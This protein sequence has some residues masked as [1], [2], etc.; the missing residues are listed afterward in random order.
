ML[1]KLSISSIL[2]F[3][4]CF[5]IFLAIASKHTQRI[6]LEQLT[7]TP[8]LFYSI[9][10][11]TPEKKSPT[12]PPVKKPK[13]SKK[14]PPPKKSLPKQQQPSRKTD[15]TPQPQ[16][17]AETI[18]DIT[19]INQQAQVIRPVTPKYPTIAQK[20]GIEATVMLEIIVDEKG[21]VA[22]A[23][24]VYCSQPGYNFEKNAIQAAKKLRFEPFIENNIPIKVKLIYPI[25]FLLIE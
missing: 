20:S 1:R 12:K 6:N 7:Q 5:L 19:Q 17:T 25:D 15:P 9:Y 13:P 10:K 8:T 4:C 21:N 11:P 14:K 24:A 3:L 18:Q 2:S 23:K 22:H 16:T